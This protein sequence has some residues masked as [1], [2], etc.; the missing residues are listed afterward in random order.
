[1]LGLTALKYG[2]Q[3]VSDFASTAPRAIW[4]DREGV[5]TLIGGVDG[6][7]TTMT[8][9]EQC[10]GFILNPQYKNQELETLRFCH[11][12]KGIKT[13]R[14]DYGEMKTQTKI[15]EQNIHRIETSFASTSLNIVFL[16]KDSAEF[17]WN[18]NQNGRGMSCLYRK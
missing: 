6:C 11:I 14:N 4:Q 16:N 1:M 12:N 18:E 2:N 3:M 17:E 13:A 7:P 9:I 10:G 15:I 8:W 5:Y